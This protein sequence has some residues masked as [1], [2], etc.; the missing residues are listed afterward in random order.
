MTRICWWLV[1]KF[2]RLL[3]PAERDAVHGDIAE[4]GETGR[5]ALFDVLGLVIR[6]QTVW[7]KGWRPW[8][9]L[10]TLVVPVG[11]LLSLISRRMA[12][13]S[14]IYI[15]LYVNNWTLDYLTNVGV[16]HDLFRDSAEIAVGYLAVLCWSWTGGFLVGSLS[17]RTIAVNGPLFCLVLLLGALFGAPEFLRYWL[18]LPRP[19]GHTTVGPTAAVFLDPFYRVIFPLM[20]QTVL[21]ALPSLW[22]IRH[23]LQLARLPR[24]LRAILWGSVTAA[25]IGMA[26]QN[27]VWWQVRTWNISPPFL[28]RLPPLLLLAVVGPVGYIVAIGCWRRWRRKDPRVPA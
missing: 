27:L 24:P 4:S 3:E 28:P 17:R 15:W 18:L 23:G 6:R 26:T 8:L 12:D 19:L 13:G 20:V 14:A 22:G 7:W 11:M 1:D 2:S 16:R 21:V 9:A 25:V 10:I 5:R